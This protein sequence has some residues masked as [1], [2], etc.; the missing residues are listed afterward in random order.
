MAVVSVQ[1][2]IKAAVGNLF[3][4]VKVNVESLK[5]MTAITDIVCL[6]SN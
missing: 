4:F 1:F 6:F 3:F 2:S 5:N